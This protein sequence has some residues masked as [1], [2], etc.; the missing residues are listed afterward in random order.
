MGSEDDEATL[1]RRNKLLQ[2]AITKDILAAMEK[3]L[4][5]KLDQRLSDRQDQNAEQR[6]EYKRQAKDQ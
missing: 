2:E 6:R 4:E 5:D 3:L 1:M